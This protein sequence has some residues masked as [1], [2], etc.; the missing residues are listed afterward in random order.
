MI[1]EKYVYSLDE[2][3]MNT[4]HQRC[5]VLMIESVITECNTYIS[6]WISNALIKNIFIHVEHNNNTVGVT[7]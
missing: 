1:I 4:V 7:P 5:L 2:F 3:E 6:V